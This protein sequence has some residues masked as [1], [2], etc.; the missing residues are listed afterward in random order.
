S[1]SACRVSAPTVVMAT[2][3][4]TPALAMFVISSRRVMATS[5]LFLIEILLGCFELFQF[6]AIRFDSF[7]TDL[8]AA[9]E[10]LRVDPSNAAERP[11]HR[12]HQ[13]GRAYR[14]SADSAVNWRVSIGRSGQMN[15]DG[16][17]SS[18]SP[19]D[20]FF[21]ATLA[22]SS[23]ADGPAIGNFVEMA[24]GTRGMCD[25]PLA[26]HFVQAPALAMAFVAEGGGKAAGVKM[27]ATRAIFVNDALV[28]ELGTIYLVQLRQ[29]AHGD[30]L[31]NHTHQVVRIGRATGKVDDWF[32]G[33]DGID[34]NRACGVGIGG[35]HTAPGRAGTDGDDRC[36][37]GGNFAQHLNG[38]L[39][40]HLHV[41]AVVLDGN[42][43][44]DHQHIFPGI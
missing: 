28:G 12:A 42:R 7:D 35:G 24:G 4:G 37:L 20:A 23:D 29:L 40:I 13:C 26:A 36:R 25:G 44:F 32:A 39:A 30:V 43:A 9:G 2:A 5:V 16:F 27:G 31:Q 3:A 15:G 22:G 11:C 18:H 14:S 38:R 1:V 10:T 8:L 41:D 17:E 33:D 19:K 21:G 34:T 6:S